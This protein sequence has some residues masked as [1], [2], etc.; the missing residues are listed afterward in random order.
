MSTFL[1]HSTDLPPKQ[2]AIRDRCF[3]PTGTFIEF[4]K[5]AVEQS[6]PDRF[7]E[8]VRRYPN[9]HALKS[10]GQELTYD[11]L[12][13]AANL[14][15]NRILAQV[16]SGN[17]PVALLIEPGA[18]VIAALLG[19]LKAGK[20]C[21]P[22]DPSFPVSRTAYMLDYSQAY[23]LVTNNRQLSLARELAEGHLPV[24]NMD[25]VDD[26]RLPEGDP[27]VLCPQTATP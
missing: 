24:I 9:R 23:L 12:N 26:R 5:E 10:Q 13:G 2:Q 21:V 25:E 15:A 11:Q 17:Q 6:I 22:L 14:V 8:Q 4:K 18:S 3:H 27:R 7:E 19:V 20:I 16:G 1:S